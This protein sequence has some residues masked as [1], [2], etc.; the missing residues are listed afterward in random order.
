MTTGR[1][2][3]LDLDE[4]AACVSCG[5]CLAYCPTFRVTGE[6]AKS[7]RG[8]IAAMRAVEQGAP[9]GD[10]FQEMMMTCVGCRAC[11]TA[12]P[13][14]VP[15]GRLME[16][17]R[18]VIPVPWW[19]RLAYRTLERPRLLSA[20]TSVGAV[21]QRAH[22]IP[23]VL[24]R[25]MSLPRLPL[26]QAPLAATGTDVWL[27]TGCVM[28]AW[29]RPVHA[30]TM[31]VLGA[32][33]AGVA[34]PGP[35]AACCGALHTHAGW[36]DRAQVL[37][38][39]VM[40]ALPGDAP[41]LVDSAG[42]GAALKEYGHLLGTPEAQRFAARVYDV[43]EWI[44]GRADRL[45]T[46]PPGRPRLRVAVQ[47]PCHLR[48]AQRAEAHVRTVLRPYADLVE[49]TDEGRCCGAGGAYSALQPEL[50]GRIRAEK[51]AVID[52]A[53][54]DVVASPNPGC[55][56]WLAAAGVPVRHPMEI[57]A[58]AAGLEVG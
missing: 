1:I 45:P 49:L 46:P 10:A 57:V 14:A 54:A 15:F 23:P 22:V 50:A 34:L 19:Q 31:A 7:P 3:P 2:L 41:I 39:R 29:Q 26:R 4:L 32:V 6:E 8:R 25:R 55:A 36:H 12:C 21:A 33:G 18:Q 53:H 13:S 38:R 44:A 30:A 51:V 24:A 40:A 42:C 5:L 11:E 48:H 52:A 56:M 27:F 20:L 16:A 9:A 47:D 35:G 37:A 17:S 28:D 58:G 43:Q